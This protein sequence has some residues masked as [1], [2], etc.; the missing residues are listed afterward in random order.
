[1]SRRVVEVIGQEKVERGD[2]GTVGCAVFV[3]LEVGIVGCCA[4]T[5]LEGTDRHRL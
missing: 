4:V 1:M 3:P 5:D 2:D